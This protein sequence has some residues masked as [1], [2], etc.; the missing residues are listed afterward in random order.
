MGALTT[1]VLD[2]FR[3]KPAAGIRIQLWMAAEREPEQA[4]VSG[5]RLL[6]ETRT[7]PDGRAAIPLAAGETLSAGVYELLFDVG[8]YYQGI[9]PTFWR[10]VPVRFCIEDPEQHYHVP[11]L[12]SP[13]G[14]TTYRGS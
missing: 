2:T 14:Y 5:R 12:I 10:E 9:A 3:G 6:C 11:L 1:H 8:R 7:G 4:S 13:W